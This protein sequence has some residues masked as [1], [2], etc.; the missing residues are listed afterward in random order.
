MD[1]DDVAMLDSKVV[2]HDT[3]HT[4]ATI[5]KLIIC[6]NNQNGVLA[7]LSLDENCITTEELKSLHGVIREGNNRVVI[8]DGISDPVYVML[9]SIYN[10]HGM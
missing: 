6:Q 9:V 7:L 8:V 1:G 4:C 2:S 10:I 3:V 5:I